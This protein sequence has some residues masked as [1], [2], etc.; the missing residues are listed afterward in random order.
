M[1]GQI[2]IALALAAML[3]LLRPVISVAVARWRNRYGR[4]VRAWLDAIAEFEALTS[5]SAYRYEHPDDAF[6]E[7]VATE[8]SSGSRALFDGVQLGHPLLPAG[9]MVRNDVHLGPGT[10]LLVVS[11]S[12]MSGKSTLLRSVGINAVLALAGAPVR[13]R[14]LRLSPLAARRDAPHPGFVAGGAVA[15][16]RGDQPD[17]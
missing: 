6:P 14:S 17:P 9:K 8:G 3:Q 11:G 7:I 2:E 10:Q 13:A 1:F 4:Q 12:N 16:L 5:L 15:L